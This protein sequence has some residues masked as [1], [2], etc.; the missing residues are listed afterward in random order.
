MKKRFKILCLL[1]LQLNVL[2]EQM[3][4]LAFAIDENN[5]QAETALNYYED[6]VIE[7]LES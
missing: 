6:K 4:D 5:P 1:C 2:S 7:I 3:E